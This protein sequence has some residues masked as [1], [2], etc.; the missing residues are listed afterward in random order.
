MLNTIIKFSLNNKLVIIITAILLLLVGTYTATEMDV[1]VFPDLTAPTVVIMTEAPGMAP[2]EVERLV[3]FPIETVVNGATDIRR[4]R[5]SSAMGLSMVWVEFDWGADIYNARQTV[6]ERL[7]QISDRLPTGTKKPIIAPQSSLMG[8]ILIFGMTSETIDPMDL[9]TLA[10]WNVRT[11]LL[12]VGGVAQVSVTGGEFKEYQIYVNPDK[13]RYYDVSLH[14][15]IDVCKNIND[16][17]SGG[18]FNQYG[19]E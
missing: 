6:T 4:V 14:E 12:S 18:F 13:M 7:I 17:A 11:R 8:E 5:S 2:E 15:L 19:T 3:T 1:D 10:E 16:N 9:R